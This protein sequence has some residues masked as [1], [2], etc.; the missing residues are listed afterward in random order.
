VFFELNMPS[1]NP[2]CHSLR[3]FTKSF[4]VHFGGIKWLRSP[5]WVFHPVEVSQILAFFGSKY[6]LRKKECSGGVIHASTCL[7]F[8]P[9]SL[10]FIYHEPS[11][12]V[13]RNLKKILFYWDH[14]EFPSL[15]EFEFFVKGR[16]IT[17]VTLFGIL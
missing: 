14:P 16:K 3:K 4:Q 2:G 10:F 1:G 15:R 12:A 5:S 9:H 11:R 6:F 8:I 13:D 17:L 7:G